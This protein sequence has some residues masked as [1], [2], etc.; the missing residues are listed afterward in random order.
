MYEIK[1]IQKDICKDGSDHL[2]SYI[3][4][5]F[6]S[7]SKLHYII[8]AEYHT[9]NIFAIKFYCKKDKRS[10][11]KYNKII[12]KNSSSTVLKILK[13]CLSLV[14]TLLQL[15]PNCNFALLSSRSVDFSSSKRLTEGLPQNQRFRIYSRF[16]QERIGN[17]TF[18]HFTYEKI[19]SYL[20]I[21]NTEH[22]I[23]AKELKVKEMFERT[24]KIVPDIGN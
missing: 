15:F 18:T 8:R 23:Y 10:D 4:K 17:V 9:E 19:S 16:I 12:N 2:F 1:F 7:D 24:Y 21:N 3:Y 11:F 6:C 20:L 14:P 13:T 5:F 22:D